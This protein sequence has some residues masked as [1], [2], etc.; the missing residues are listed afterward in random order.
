MKFAF[1]NNSRCSKVSFFYADSMLMFTGHVSTHCLTKTIKSTNVRPYDITFVKIQVSRDV[2]CNY[3]V[4]LSSSVRCAE[5][6][7]KI[8]PVEDAPIHSDI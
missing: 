8:P 4:N 6:I 2:L 1:I 5:G 7:R 3:G